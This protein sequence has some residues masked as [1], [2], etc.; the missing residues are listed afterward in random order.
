MRAPVVL[1]TLGALVLLVT[2]CGGGGKIGDEELHEQL[3]A[4][5]STA[6]EGALLASDVARGRTLGP[7]ADVHS[8]VLAAQAQTAA[9]FLSPDRAQAGLEP[10][11]SRAARLAKSVE[12]S[13]DE[14]ETA[15]GDRAR[16]LARDLQRDA[17]EAERLGS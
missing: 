14:L 1:A 4:V 12:S 17:D 5:Q 2:G 10:D 15:G 16:I 6:A 3:E 9:S 13:L 7:F 8:R 11:V